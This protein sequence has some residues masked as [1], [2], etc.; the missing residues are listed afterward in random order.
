VPLFA[1]IGR[2]GADGAARRPVQRPAHLA[3]WAPL[4]RAGRVRFAGPL[5]DERG[6]PRGSVLV[7]EASDRDAAHAHAASDPYVTGGVFERFELFETAQVLP[8]PPEA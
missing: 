2:D 4:A 6:E 8:E 7:F 5:R 3:H 1:V